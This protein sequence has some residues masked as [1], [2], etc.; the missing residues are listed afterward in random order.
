MD[1]CASREFDVVIVGGGPAGAT[2]AT[3]LARRG[4]SVLLLDRAGRIKPCGGAIPPKLIEEFAIPES[5]LVA[6][7]TAAR[8]VSPASKCVDMPIEG[9]FVGMVDREVFD[10]WLRARAASVGAIR[11]DGT[12]ESLTHDPDGTAVVHFR[13]FA[14]SRAEPLSQVRTRVVIG[15]DGAQSA[16]ARQCLSSDRRVP[17]VAAY[18]EIVRFP[19]GAAAD[20]SA[21]RCDIYYQGKLS[22]DFYAWIFPHGDTLSIG[23][24]S[25]QKGFSLR[26]AVESLRAQ[27]GLSSTETL[28]CEG[29]PIPL[30]P[31]PRWD[32]GRDV[33]LAGDAAGVVAPASGEGIYYAMAGGRYAA[34]AVERFLETGAVT[35][36]RVARRRFMQAHGRVFFILRIMQRFLVFRRPATGE[37]RQHLSR[38]RCPTPHVGSVYVQA[39]RSGAAPGAPADLFQRPVAPRRGRADMNAIP[40]TGRWRAMLSGGGSLRARSPDWVRSLPSSILGITG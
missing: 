23:V 28:R 16:V 3:D 4:R 31:L 35:A 12:F 30:R 21:S 2:A 8:M 1:G 9:G 15:A 29:A 26:R 32:N 25:A 24:G 20:C 36:L 17:Y 5:L 40:V 33:I 18:H 39:A 6:R 34:E 10:E 19:S 14:A 27:T 11:R 13:R 38:S 22:P 7:A 37:I